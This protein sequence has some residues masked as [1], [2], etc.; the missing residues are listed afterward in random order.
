MP[1]YHAFVVLEQWFSTLKQS[2]KLFG[3]QMQPVTLKVYSEKR[4]RI[5]GLR[6]N[7]NI[8]LYMYIVL[9]DGCSYCT[10]CYVIEERLCACV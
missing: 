3:N 9:F 2:D 4:L 10:V 8:E 6:V 1:G 5:T 7:S